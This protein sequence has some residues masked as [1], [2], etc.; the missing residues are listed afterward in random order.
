MILIL[1]LIDSAISSNREWTRMNANIWSG[2]AGAQPAGDGALAV[3]NLSF[4]LGLMYVKVLGDGKVG[5]I[6]G[7]V[8]EKRTDHG[9]DTSDHGSF[10]D[11]CEKRGDKWVIVR[12]HSSWVKDA[13]WK[14]RV[15]R[16]ASLATASLRPLVIVWLQRRATWH[17]HLADG[18]SRRCG[19]PNT[20]EHLALAPPAHD[21][22]L[23]PDREEL[24][25]KHA[26]KT[27]MSG[28]E[29]TGASPIGD[30]APSGS[31]KIMSMRPIKIFIRVH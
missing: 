6:Q 5:V 7:T 13:K 22:D 30:G 18:T 20:P 25:A 10:M 17:R 15:D 8:T 1:I 3:A 27:S 29:S 31:V 28:L 9:E 12:S 11:V 16:T 23:D 21:H 24:T 14:L 19:S 26:K 4:K 2:S